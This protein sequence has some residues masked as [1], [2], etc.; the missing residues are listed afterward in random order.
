[1]FT[2]CIGQVSGTMIKYIQIQEQVNAL[3][4]ILRVEIIVASHYEAKVIPVLFTK[5]YICMK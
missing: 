4:L 5:L 3:I 1:M 2:E